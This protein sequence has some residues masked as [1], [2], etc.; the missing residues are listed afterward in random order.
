DALPGPELPPGRPELAHEERAA[1]KQPVRVRERGQDDPSRRA[2]DV[3]P[4]E[5]DVPELMEKPLVER[6]VREDVDRATSPGRP[7]RAL[8]ALRVPDQRRIPREA[9]QPDSLTD[10]F[11]DRLRR[12][13]R[14]PLP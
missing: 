13:A 9:G 14:H 2:L 1:A 12:P 7:H 3:P 10:P 5:G 8:G 11:A 6:P 4:V